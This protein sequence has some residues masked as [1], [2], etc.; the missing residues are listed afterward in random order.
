MCGGDKINK[1]ERSSVCNAETDRASAKE[2]LED[3]LASHS[4]VLQDPWEGS[5]WEET[6]SLKYFPLPLSIDPTVGNDNYCETQSK[7]LGGDQSYVWPSGDTF[8]GHIEDGKK[9]GWGLVASPG[10]GIV[11]LSGDW[12]EGRLEGKGRLVTVNSTVIEG[13]FRHSC[14]H[15]LARK[16]EIK[17]FRTFMQ[18]AGGYQLIRYLMLLIGDLAGAIQ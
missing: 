11:S 9:S 6:E 17:K 14:L 16:I 10:N 13:W 3:W 4:Q 18:Q 12:Q 15:G 1:K 8:T 7:S 2:I 5:E